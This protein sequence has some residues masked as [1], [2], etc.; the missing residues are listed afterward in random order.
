M[1]LTVLGSG[2]S[3]NGY[4]LTDKNGETLIIEAG[5]PA[6]DVFRKVKHSNVVGMIASHVHGDHLGRLQEYLNKRITTYIHDTSRKEIKK[7]ITGYFFPLYFSEHKPF[8]LGKFTIIAFKLQHDTPCFGF[9]IS[10]PDM[11]GDLLFCTDTGEIP[12]TFE[13]ITTLLVEADYDYDILKANYDSGKVNKW[14]AERIV[15]THL[16]VDKAIA[17]TKTLDIRELRNVV[18]LHLSKNNANG[19]L[20]KEKFIKE[21]GKQVYIA[22]P[23][24]E[25][26]IGGAF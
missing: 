11:E 2:S 16:S 22:S 19:D 17:F 4:L 20:F 1:K 7:P 8:N 24:L 25:V 21:T 6:S 26:E 14:L 15:K 5:I 12:Y 10:H 23:G 18:L 3:G 9:L 13:N